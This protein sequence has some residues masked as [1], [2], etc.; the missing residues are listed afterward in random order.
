MKP[1]IL[2]FLFGLLLPHHVTVGQESKAA[3]PTKTSTTKAAGDPV[4]ADQLLRTRRAQ[5]RSLLVALST[6][7]RS[8]RDQ[9]LRARSLARIADALWQVDPEQSRSLFRKAWEA[10]EIA[11]QESNQKFQEEMNQQKA[12]TGGFVGNLAPSIRREVLRLTARRDRTL[13][14][15]FLEKLRTQT[16]E[17]ANNVV[18]PGVEPA[19]LSEAMSQRLGVARSLLQTGEIERALQFADP[20]LQTVT[21]ETVSFLTEVREKAPGPADTRYVALLSLS[22][23]NPQSDANTVSLLSSYIFTPQLYIIFTG[24]GT[25]SSQRSSTITPAN[26]SADL[27]AAFFQTAAGILLRPIPPAG[28][29]QSTSGLDGK[30]LVIKRLLP[31]FEQYTAPEMVE[32]LRGQLNALNAVVSDNARKRDDESINRGVKPEVPV[33]DLEQALLDRIE[34]AKTSAERDSAYIQ[35]ANLMMKTGDMRARD[36][37]GKIEELELRKQFQAYVD[38]RLVSY[39]IDKK[40]T[41]Q[42]LELVHRGELTHL[43]KAWVLTQCAQL[44]LT[45]DRQK[46][47]ELVEEA[48]LEARRMEESDPYFPRALLAIANTLRL[49]D[50]PRVWDATFDAVKAANSAEGFSGEDGQLTFRFQSRGQSSVHSNSV[51]DFDLDGIFRELAH[52]DYDRAVELARGFQAEGP[53]AIATIAIARGILEEKKAAPTAKK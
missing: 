24:N 15:E 17:A 9:V 43:Q 44:L 34:R 47:L 14:E 13:G 27:R 1:V 30:Y 28:Q 45:T 16:V 29:D 40:Q 35:L 26:V 2:L 51:A 18:K 25:S 32:S 6:D 20:A 8:F 39:A 31:L 36:Y 10:A 12:K 19:R 37:A 4:A 21:M 46:A 41:E 33:A 38:P 48:V 23:N 53:R 5:A 3:G 22:S 49:L 11:D 50:P 52:Q 42:A 7:A